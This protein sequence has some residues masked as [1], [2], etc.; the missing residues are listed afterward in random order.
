MAAKERRQRPGT[1]YERT[2]TESQKRFHTMLQRYSLGADAA[3]REPLETALWKEYG[4]QRVVL[5]VDMSGFSRLTLKHGIIHYL[6]MVLK[7]RE[8]AKPIIE[9]HG[10]ALVRFE[11]DNAFAMF[12]NS[13][14][15]IRSAIA[16]NHAFDREN[17]ATAEELDIHIACGI[18]RGE[19]LV[20]ERYLEFWGNAVNR[21]SKLGEDLAAAGQI[22]I[23]R[24]VADSLPPE[25]DFTLKPVRVSISGIEIEGYAVEYSRGARDT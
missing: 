20:V 24:E 22:L 4:T 3:A 21:A 1:L 12:E 2:M 8:T 7:M 18:D 23:T 25:R 17:V 16:L 11:A 9:E 19:I 10:G 5:A 14:E 15:A 13:L 6:A